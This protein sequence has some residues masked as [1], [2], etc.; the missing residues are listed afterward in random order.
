AP[1]DQPPVPGPLL[2]V[3]VADT[4]GWQD[5]TAW[6]STEV[7]SAQAAVA[8]LTQA[9]TVAGELVESYLAVRWP[10]GLSP[11]P[12]LVRGCAVALAL[13]DLLGARA[14]VPEGPY[15]GIVRRAKAAHQTLAGLRDGTLTLGVAV[16]APAAPAVR[17]TVADRSSTMDSLKGM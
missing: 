8:R 4:E 13:D 5:D 7:E 3:A 2:R 17:M 9:C 12:G 14:A 16:P 6:L 15:A 10:A 1:S 11:V